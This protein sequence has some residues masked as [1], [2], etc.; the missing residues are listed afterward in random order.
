MGEQLQRTANEIGRARQGA[1]Q[2]RG[3]PRRNAALQGLAQLFPEFFQSLDRARQ[4]LCQRGSLT[5]TLGRFQG[6]D[7]FEDGASHLLTNAKVHHGPGGHNEHSP[8]EG[9]RFKSILP[10]PADAAK[11]AAAKRTPVPARGRP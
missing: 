5:R 6:G 4:E 7:L 9:M 11:T 3:V 1:S 8:L 10:A 2:G